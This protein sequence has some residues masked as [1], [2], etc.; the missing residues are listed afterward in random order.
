MPRHGERRWLGIVA[1]YVVFV[2]VLVLGTVPAYVFVEADHRQAVVRLATA[3]L[4]GSVLTHVRRSLGAGED[5]PG[6]APPPVETEPTLYRGFTE[7]YDGMRQSIRSQGYFEAILWPRL[8]SLVETDQRTALHKPAG[9]R[10]RRGPSA[11]TLGE[12]IATLE[13]RA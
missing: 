6:A 3:I 7:L 5:D 13:R 12:L 4:V 1:G 8:L 11:A 10:F 9:R 2:G